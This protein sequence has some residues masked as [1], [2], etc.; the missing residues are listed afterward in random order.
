MKVH[1][2]GELNVETDLKLSNLMHIFS[3][4]GLIGKKIKLCFLRRLRYIFIN[5][6]KIYIFRRF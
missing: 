2:S 6:I 1:I 5:N 3:I 4:D